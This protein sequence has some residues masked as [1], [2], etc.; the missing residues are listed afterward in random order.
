VSRAPGQVWLVGGGPGEAGLITV[1]G[2]RRLREADVVVA[3]RLAPREL[4]A[5]LGPEVEVIDVGKAPGNHPV[6]QETINRLLVSHARAG[7][8]VVRLKGGD[9][10]LFGRGQEELEACRTAG[11]PVGVVPGVSSAFAAPAAAGIPVTRRGRSGSVTVITGHDVLDRARLAA[12]ATLAGAGGTIVVLMG[13]SHLDDLTEGLLDAGLDGAVPAAV[14]ESAWTP[15]QRT[16]VARLDELAKVAGE[17][18]VRP[19]AVI[20]VGDVVALGDQLGDVLPGD[21]APWLG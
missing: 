12:L 10:Y 2:L 8:V 14:I 18:Q 19:P 11:V 13:V 20:V 16:T 6:P 17:A 3:D 7:R 21:T 15:Q 9:P 5:E 1:E 4:L